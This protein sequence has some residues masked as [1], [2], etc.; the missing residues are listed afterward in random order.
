M[1][2]QD[3]LGKE[4]IDMKGL[5]AYLDGLDHP[6]RLREVRT[7]TAKQQAALFEA[8]KG[9]RPLSLDDFV[10]KNIPPL[11]PVIH[12]GKNSL[13]F[14]THFQKPMCRPDSTTTP[15]SLWGYNEQLLKPVT[16]PGYFMTKPAEAGEVV[17]DY[18]SVPSGKPSGWPE[19]L[20]NSAGL[21]RFVYY[22]T[23]DF[24]RG[25]SKHVS[26]G[27]ATRNG[28]PMNN[29]FVLCREDA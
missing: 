3:F 26:I 19:I 25:V 16:G 28:K 29:W 14:F 17:I 27:R 18:L 8:A 23:R 2:I 4:K 5:A 21:S 12:H 13:P 15:P 22:Q 6:T 11:K 20:P 24:M 9:F 10:P 1:A 7:L